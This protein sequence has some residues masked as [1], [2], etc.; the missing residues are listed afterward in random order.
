MRVGEIPAID[1]DA[2]STDHRLAPMIY[3]SRKLTCETRPRALFEITE[4]VQ[5]AV[6]KSGCSSGVAHVFV[7][8]T[9]ASLVIGENADPTVLADLERFFRRLVPD[10]DPV[11]E[12]VAEGPDDMPAHVRSILTQTT[13]TIPI[14]HNRCD[15]GTWQGIFLWEHRQH[16]QQRRVTVS[17][18]GE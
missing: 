1:P 18:V 14:A 2:A 10:G 6:A 5:K 3:V 13:L 11:F 12:H 16:S 8:H 4:Q 9:S 15:L 7:H 17:V